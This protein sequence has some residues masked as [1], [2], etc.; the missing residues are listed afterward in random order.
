[1][2]CQI[3]ALCAL[4]IS[5]FLGCTSNTQSATKPELN[6]KESRAQQTLPP[7][8]SAAAE[9]EKSAS[10][11]ALEILAAKLSA[12]QNDAAAHAALVGY[13]K[14]YPIQ[15]Q[16]E[17][18]NSRLNALKALPESKSSIETEAR[19]AAFKQRAKELEAEL[20]LGAK[21][22]NAVH[23][24]RVDNYDEEFRSDL[25]MIER[26]LSRLQGAKA[27]F[28]DYL[29]SKLSNQAVEQTVEFQSKRLAPDEQGFLPPLG[30]EAYSQL[31]TFR[32]EYDREHRARIEKLFADN[33]AQFQSARSYAQELKRGLEAQRADLGSVLASHNA[34]LNDMLAKAESRASYSSKALRDRA[35]QTFQTH[36]KEFMEL[37]AL[38]RKIRGEAREAAIQEVI[39]QGTVTREQV[40]SLIAKKKDDDSDP[41]AGLSGLSEGGGE[42][43]GELMSAENL[44]LLVMLLAA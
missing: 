28:K 25:Q 11:E 26:A 14:E 31:A 23:A 4:A 2:R 15:P 36:R 17:A 34:S 10:A 22:L 42:G 30:A 43:E 8:T 38:D 39:R 19:A 16:T 7:L 27:S 6:A 9:S 33:R 3:L 21:V 44:K 1:M 18:L 12:A 24:F 32:R 35:E 37:V 41:T 5:F 20:E 13:L 29:L 40:E